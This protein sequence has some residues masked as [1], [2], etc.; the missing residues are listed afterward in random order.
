MSLYYYILNLWNNL[1]LCQNCNTHV[2]LK[3]VG[4]SS[5]G[6]ALLYLQTS[7]YILNKQGH[8][9]IQSQ[10]NHKNQEI[11]T[12][13]FYHPPIELSVIVPRMTFAQNHM[14]RCV[15]LVCLH[16]YLVFLT[17]MTWALMKITDLLF[18]RVLFSDFLW[19]FIMIRLR[20]FFGRHSL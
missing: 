12:D 11:N 10:N 5:P 13:I 9:P 19:C 3:H 15:F 4:V 8:S 2:F 7:V 1:N 18:C 16:L 20:L 6:D 14:L 17:F